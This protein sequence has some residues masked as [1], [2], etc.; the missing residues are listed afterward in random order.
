MVFRNSDQK[1]IELTCPGVYPLGIEPYEIEIPLTEV[2]LEPGDR[3]LI[4]TDGLTERFDGEGQTYGE[5][6]LLKLLATD[7]A[8]D[9][10]GVIGAIM[11]DVEQFAGQLPAD[12]DQA[13]LLGIVQN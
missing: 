12:D 1:A 3:F 7:S 9:P 8:H 10:Q 4:Y 5:E 6:R 13:L 11:A 2:K